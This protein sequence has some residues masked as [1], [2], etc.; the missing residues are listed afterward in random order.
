MILE[1]LGVLIEALRDGSIE[2]AQIARLDQLLAEHPEALEH[3]VDRAW[4]SADLEFKLGRRQ[5]T[6]LKNVCD[7]QPTQS[8]RRVPAKMLWQRALRRPG[9]QV[10]ARA[11]RFSCERQVN[12]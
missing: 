5:A 8:I 6:L 4:L 3:F 9:M 10:L 2:D 7:L 12:F 11:H 1:E